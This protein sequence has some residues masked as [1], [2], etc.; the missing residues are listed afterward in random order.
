MHTISNGWNCSN[1]LE[2]T[3][4]PQ[5]FV[6]GSKVDCHLQLPQFL[7]NRSIQLLLAFISAVCLVLEKPTVLLPFL[8]W[9]TFYCWY[10]QFLR[11]TWPVNQT[12]GWSYN[13]LTLTRDL[14]IHIPFSSCH[15]SALINVLYTVHDMWSLIPFWL[16]KSLLSESEL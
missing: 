2:R 7:P 3:H 12:V 5:S 15:L 16:K 13:S 6:T 14:N 1:F 8:L 9:W 11:T 10:T 4:C